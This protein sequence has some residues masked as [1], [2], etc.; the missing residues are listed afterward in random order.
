MLEVNELLARL[1]QRHVNAGWATGGLLPAI[2]I[3]GHWN[4]DE[5]LSGAGHGFWSAVSMQREH[6]RNYSREDGIVLFAD[7]VRFEQRPYPRHFLL[8]NVPKLL[9][10]KDL[11]GYADESTA[12]SVTLFDRIG[13]LA[14]VVALHEHTR[15]MEDATGR[16]RADL[17]PQLSRAGFGTLLR[18]PRAFYHVQELNRLEFDKNRIEAEIEWSEINAITGH[19]LRHFTRQG[20]GKEGERARLV[21]DLAYGFERRWSHVAKQIA[22]LREAFRSRLDYGLQQVM[23]WLTVVGLLLAVPEAFRTKLVEHVLELFRSAVF[24]LRS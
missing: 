7:D 16:M 17:A 24:L 8:V 19:E 6:Y 12:I 4:T 1:L 14:V 13:H 2:E 20:F 11:A 5:E 18:W 15:R 10:E 23:T 3:F 22:V 21:D 9:E